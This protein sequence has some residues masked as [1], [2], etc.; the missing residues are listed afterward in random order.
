MPETEKG[1]QV[2]QEVVVKLQEQ[3]E[4]LNKGIASYRDEANSYKENYTKLQQDLEELKG[5]LKSEDEDDNK[6]NLNPEDEKRLEAWA[7]QKGFVSQNEFQAER[8]KIQQ[9]SIKN[10]ETQAVSQFLEKNPEY[11]NDEKWQEVLREFQLY[12]QPT[13]LDAYSKLLNRIHNDLS[14]G[15]RKAEEGGRVKEKIETHIKGRLSLGGG[16]QGSPSD[17]DKDVDNLQ[18]R[19]PNL[20]RDEIRTRLSELESLYPKK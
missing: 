11:D 12:R 19:Y 18:K 2:T 5:S 9:D 13:S 16:H 17:N 8:Q 3:I 1:E 14:G 15:I 4:N 20:S 6:V 7:K 10:V